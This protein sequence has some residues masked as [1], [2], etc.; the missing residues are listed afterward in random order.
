LSARASE[1][2]ES[3]APALPAQ[4]RTIITEELDILKRLRAHLAGH[5]PQWRDIN[6]DE[7]LL[8][9]R[10]ELGEARDDEVAAIVHQMAN[11]ASLSTHQEQAR[12]GEAALDPESPYFGHLRVRQDGRVR[13][14]LIGNRTLASSELPYAIID[15]RH[16]PISK[17]Y[18]LYREGDE[19]EE[20]FGG[21]LV[22]GKILAH[23]KLMILR[24]HLVRIDCPDGVFTLD[25]GHWR[26]VARARPAMGGGAGS[27]LRPGT[28][29]R[30]D[31]TGLLGVTHNDVHRTDKHLAA[32][33]G[34]I[35]PVQFEL[36]TRPE[37]GV[38]VID[39]GAGSG[40]TTIGLHRIAYL[41]YRDPARFEPKRMLV[42]VF[43][44]ALAAYIVKLL[45]ALGVEGVRTEVFED[46]V[47]DL[48]QRHFPTLASAYDEA[49]PATVVRFKQ[50]PATLA[51]LE[52]C[53]AERTAAA[54]RALADAAGAPADAEHVRAAWQA[55][56]AL[57][58][59][60]RL[61][62][63]A[64]WVRGKATAPRAGAFRGDWLVR[65]RLGNHLIERQAELQQPWL[66]AQ[67]VW[68]EAFL[69]LQRLRAA[70]ERLAPGEFTPG[71]L[72]EVRNWA[73]R[74]YSELEDYR[75]WQSQRGE[76]SDEDETAAPAADGEAPT[77]AAP[78][79]RVD[80]EDDALLLL[81]YTRMV[82]PLRSRRKRALRFQHILVDEAQDFSPLDLQVLIA[83]AAEPISVTLAGDT[84]QRMIIHNAFTRWEDVIAQLG[85]ES[86][87]ISP[88]QVGYRSTG[89]IMEFARA[90]LGA[91]ATERPWIATRPGVPVE[92]LRFTD[93]GQAVAVLSE[94]LLSLVRRESSASVALVT[95]YP[96][97][98]DLYWEGLKRADLP[99][100]RRVAEQDF[101]FAPGIEVT[102][103]TQVK[104][105]EF[106]YVI[107]L[108]VDQATYPDD[109]PSRYLLH[110]AATRAAHQLLLVTCRTPSPLLPTALPVHLL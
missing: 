35:D 47:G 57:P 100:L 11:L 101:N 7:A 75:A 80:R 54:G 60:P 84:D 50:H 77:Q 73:F 29:Q 39:G 14:I 103:V 74:T 22:E 32:I 107:L 4:A 58:L 108:D 43:G 78:V 31:G 52:Q 41:A 87:A 45:P 64:D 48:R 55:W 36:I 1:L 44:R 91:L 63:M 105:L 97:Q 56:A 33:T 46:F 82:G 3:F 6:Y 96:A 25:N 93:A 17:V 20:E 30:V 71:Q 62:H 79:A 99:G 2:L 5:V 83:L 88:L 24:G 95:R 10:D 16:A 98:A 92:L 110:I 109:T 38:V 12:G 61:Q 28:L 85:L 23:R 94:E 8:E 19:Y 106:D 86:T 89:H 53:V 18:Y 34:L 13:D 68:E 104:G 26:E 27:A 102:D 9:L 69:D 70:L 37:S 40:K 21:K 67:G 42:V 81:L 51:Y 76:P 59:A 49:T 15:W 65:Q 66:L 90:V 72:E